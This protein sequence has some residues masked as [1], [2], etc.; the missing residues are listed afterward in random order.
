MA[1]NNIEKFSKKSFIYF[2]IVS[3]SLHLCFIGLY[4]RS[5]QAQIVN[6]NPSSMPISQ[7]QIVINDQQKFKNIEKEITK[8]KQPKKAKNKIL[9]KQ[10]TKKNYKITRKNNSQKPNFK[11]MIKNFVEPTY[12]RIALRRGWAGNVLLSVDVSKDGEVLRVK[13]IKSS[14]HDVLDESAIDAAKKWVFNPLLTQNTISFNKRVV[15]NNI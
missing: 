2:F 12:P 10:L 11:S 5:Q 6:V 3:F 9:N 14:G 8:K 7:I 4:S 1:I 15:F 13:I